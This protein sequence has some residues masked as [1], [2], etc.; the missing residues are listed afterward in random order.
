MGRAVHVGPAGTLGSSGLSTVLSI[1]QMVT[2]QVSLYL[3]PEH[4]LSYRYWGSQATLER[5]A[6]ATSAVQVDT[7]K[8]YYH[9]L[10]AQNQKE[11]HTSSLNYGSSRA[12]G[13][14]WLAHAFHSPFGAH[15]R[16]HH[17]Q[18]VSSTPL[19]EQL[20]HPVGVAY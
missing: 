15:A 11:S 14:S 10:R 6:Q 1:A 19:L 4:N 8:T 12:D 13:T 18:S 3:A 2:L 5:L 9:R 16:M 7:E 17:S 20:E